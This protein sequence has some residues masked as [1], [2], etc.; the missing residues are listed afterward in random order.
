MLKYEKHLVQCQA[1]GK[2][3][4]KF[5]VLLLIEHKPFLLEFVW[6]KEVAL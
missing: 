4:N 6:I 1:Y 3:Y 5:Q 2:H